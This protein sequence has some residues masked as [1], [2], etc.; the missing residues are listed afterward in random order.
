MG[1]SL[2]NKISL[3]YW[4]QTGVKKYKKR[5]VFN[6]FENNFLYVYFYINILIKT[7][8]NLNQENSLKKLYNKI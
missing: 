3:S 1:Y 8:T 7:S 5:F 4:L 6:F 2:K